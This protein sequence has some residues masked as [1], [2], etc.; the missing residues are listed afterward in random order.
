MT[1]PVELHFSEQYYEYVQRLAN[2]Q[3]PIVEK[4]MLDSE[5]EFLR[6]NIER[7]DLSP[8]QQN[9]IMFRLIFCWLHGHDVSFAFSRVLSGTSI[10]NL[11]AKRIAYLT[12]N[13]FLDEKSDITILLGAQLQIDL[14]K[15]NDPVILKCALQTTAEIMPNDLIP[16]LMPPIRA[17]IKHRSPVVRSHV[18]LVFN[19]YLK[20]DREM[21]L[22]EL[23]GS[24]NELLKLFNT[25]SHSV[26][27]ALMTLWM[28]C[29]KDLDEAQG[30]KLVDQTFEILQKLIHHKFSDSNDFDECWNPFLLGKILQ[31]L[32]KT[33]HFAADLGKFQRILKKIG[34]TF[35]QTRKFNHGHATIFLEYIRLISSMMLDDTLFKLVTEINLRLLKDHR[36]NILYCG[37]CSFKYLL[38]MGYEL[39]DVEES[40][41]LDCLRAKDTTLQRASFDLLLKMCTSEN[42]ATIS[43]IVLEYLNSLR[44]SLVASIK[45]DL[46]EQLFDVL[47]EICDDVFVYVSVCSKLLIFAGEDSPSSSKVQEK[48]QRSMFDLIKNGTGYDELQDQKIN[49]EIADSFQSIFFDDNSEINYFSLSFAFLRVI[50][51]IIPLLYQKQIISLETA[52]KM[53]I[54][55]IN[56]PVV[57]NNSKLCEVLINSFVELYENNQNELEPMVE[58]IINILSYVYLITPYSISLEITYNRAIMILCDKELMFN[59]E[60][61][62]TNIDELVLQL[63][64][65]TNIPAPD[66]LDIEETSVVAKKSSLKIDSYASPAQALQ[67][68]SVEKESKNQNNLFDG[69]KMT[70]SKSAPSTPE[71]RNSKVKPVIPQVKTIPGSSSLFDG[72]KLTKSKS[73]VDNTLT[74]ANSDIVVAKKESTL[75]DLF[76][77]SPSPSKSENAKSVDLLDG[78]LASSQQ[79]SHPGQPQKST[80]VLDDLFDQEIGSVSPKPQTSSLFDS[81]TSSPSKPSNT[82][83]NLFSGLNVQKQSQIQNFSNGLTQSSSI[84]FDSTIASN[85]FLKLNVSFQPGVLTLIVENRT[86]EQIGNLNVTFSDPAPGKFNILVN[87][88]ANIS[89]NSAI[90]YSLSPYSTVEIKLSLV[91][92]SHLPSTTLTKINVKANNQINLNAAIKLSNIDL[93]TPLI[94]NSNEFSQLAKQLRSN[95]PSEEIYSNVSSQTFAALRNK[96]SQKGCHVISP[97]PSNTNQF[98]ISA[99]LFICPILMFLDNDIMAKK[100]QVKVMSS[101]PSFSSEFAKQFKRIL[102]DLTKPSFTMSQTRNTAQNQS[103]DILDSL[104]G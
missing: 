61:V 33:I 89:G 12:C 20:V 5:Y 94:L 96:M 91:E 55:A 9:E 3:N 22:I 36:P 43:K 98:A 42:I 97:D 75:S 21:G 48:I 82:T 88:A 84:S 53:L 68:A 83:N 52:V 45:I 25:E 2:A 67:Q 49:R 101:N 34:E 10:N 7:T 95:E 19:K 65:L 77:L 16:A 70:S 38:D 66:Y 41:I 76:N 30:R 71:S 62:S 13:S 90:I 47:A 93:L 104:F 86:K 1:T 74:K 26:L 29:Y 14:Q 37:L 46:A 73:D 32:S 35:I 31:C 103:S 64:P 78:L 58:E 99:N 85:T 63:I 50:A 54:K 80:D 24:F 11:F 56:H 57:R 92:I 28:T 102:D 27:Q 6:K 17:L 100:L 79:S 39:T 81:L 72:L 23:N 18:I 51:N 59:H 69:L 15:N 87:A 4:R 8:V 44:I 40:V 60:N